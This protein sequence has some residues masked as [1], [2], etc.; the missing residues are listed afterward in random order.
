MVKFLDLNKQYQSIKNE[1][2]HAI[3]SVIDDTAFVGGKYPKMFEEAFAS[4][5]GANHCITVGNGTDA[6]EIAIES[7]NLPENSE[8]IVP[9]N[10][11]I[12]SSESITRAGKK[13][14]FCDQDENYTISVED[15]KNRTQ[16]RQ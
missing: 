3:K 14:R 12:A 8:I 15:I 6:L 2:D 4:Y 13:V 16:S 11:F 7:L 5:I 1:I 9:A 10:S